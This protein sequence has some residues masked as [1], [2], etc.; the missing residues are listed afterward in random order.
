[1]NWNQIAKHSDLFLILGLVGT[2]VVMLF[3]IPP[4]VMDLFFVA[5]ITMSVAILLV[6]VYTTRPL[7]FSVFP[8]ILLFST[9]FRLSLNVASTRLVLL[10]GH[11][12]PAAAGHIIE[13]FGNL[14]VGGSYVVGVVVFVLLIII[15]FIVITKGSGRVAEVAARFIL[16]A[17]PGKQMS[18]DADLNAG[19]INEEQARDRRK[20]I[21]A[22]ADF[23]GAMDGAS[24]FVRGDA[25]A[26]VL[27]TVVNIIGGFAI[28]IL[29]KGLPLAEAAQLYTLMTIG[30]GL[31]SQIPSLIVSTAA[32][33][34]VTRAASGENLSQELAKQVLF[35]PK[36]IGVT[37]TILILMGLFP[38]VPFMPFFTLGAIMGGIAWAASQHKK[39]ELE[40]K[41]VE[42]R[43]KAEA[44]AHETYTP[45]EVDTLELQVGYGLVG[46]VE[47]ENKGD[48]VDRIYQLRKEFARDLGI[49]VPKVRI[50][51]NLELQAN[52]YSILIKGVSV[53]S[54]ELM[55]G[56]WLAMDPGGVEGSVPGIPTKEPVF[57]LNALWINEK[58]KERAQIAGYT[59]VDASTII[60]THLSELVRKHAY[61]LIGRQDL[62]GLIQ[63][64]EK[65]HPKVVEE[66]IPKLLPLGDVL[67]VTQNLLR[68][69]VPVRDLLTILETLAN[70]AP[71]Y[72]DPDVLT[73]F[74]RAALARTITNR[75]THGAEELEVLTLDARTEE[76]LLRG[77]QRTDSGS[78]INLEPGA[79]EKLV[80]ELQNMIERTAFSSGNAVL[81]CHPMI[82]SQLKRLLERFI[83]N[84]N[85]VSANEIANSARVRSLG[86]VAA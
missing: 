5:S 36:A 83:P 82:R 33:I 70:Y 43:K 27:I 23:Y 48:L 47:G 77:Y 37:A 9:L 81:L 24:K 76:T 26:G 12:G 68:E 72:K 38:G 19:L 56:F 1:M 32:G 79:F 16:D 42:E 6:S 31:V 61:E 8:T 63:N 2:I 35:H 3:P 57:G 11:E 74:V 41:V 22:E 59:V 15:N 20:Q 10:H 13:T 45:P 53:G 66:L 67:K 69:Q 62:Q 49:I 17:M 64:I 78:S 44:T 86:A 46:L 25:I 4:F 75:L 71:K 60:A 14:V 73:E 21:E 18:I 39:V 55:N 54:G 29:Q 58:D 52:G 50:K 51:D 65:T 40:Q 34:V 7:D 28:G 80:H 30:D 84:L 85:I